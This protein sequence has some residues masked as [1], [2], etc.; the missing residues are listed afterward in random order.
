MLNGISNVDLSTP[1]LISDTGNNQTL[2]TLVWRITAQ[3][4]HEVMMMGAFAGCNV[5]KLFPVVSAVAKLNGADS[6]PY[7]ATAH[8]A[9][10]DANF[11]KLSRCSLFIRQ[12]AQRDPSNGIDDRATCERDLGGNPGK[13]A[14]RFGNVVIPFY[15]DGTKCFFKVLPITDN[16]MQTLRGVTLANRWSGSLR[17]DTAFTFMT[18]TSCFRFYK[19]RHIL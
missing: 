10:Y 7:A 3:T 15:F 13:Q 11:Y 16:E 8:E 17:T 4:G 12:Q 18:L 1:I 9:L 5:G 2:L 19:H 6:I 14:A